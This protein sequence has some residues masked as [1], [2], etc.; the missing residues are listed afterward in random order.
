MRWCG[1]LPLRCA[2]AVCLAGILGAAGE[3][4][5]AEP[6]AARAAA[7]RATADSVSSSGPR[8]EP[9]GRLGG[10]RL[11]TGRERPYLVAFTFD[12]GPSHVTTP[13]ILDALDRYGVPATF[14]VVG[15]RFA[16]STEGAR[17]N[18]AVL[19][20]IARRGHLVGNH[21]FGHDHLGVA[22]PRLVARTV[23]RNSRAI[24]R[25]LGGRPGLFRP[26][27]GM[28]GRPAAGYLRRA[29][30][31]VV[32][33]SVDPKDFASAG[34]KSLRW[35]VVQEILAERGGIVLLHDTKRWTAAALPHILADLEAENCRR[36]AAGRRPVI[37]VSL[38]YFLRE[39]S[40]RRRPVPP[41]VEAR[42]RLYRAGLAAR[43]AAVRRSVDK[44]RRSH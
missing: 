27:Y 34:K 32:D 4:V 36:L 17:K 26:P 5:R 18:A 33:W 35:R 8:A 31:T 44:L 20:E 7:A 6:R 29:G 25:V 12:D 10:A 24:A 40:G 41:E 22:E 14:F 21:T 28:L 2:L 16:R 9:G 23:E 30:Y 38:H 19:A 42:T 37:P 39:R 15:R 3:P 1:V 11:V 43:C 13:L